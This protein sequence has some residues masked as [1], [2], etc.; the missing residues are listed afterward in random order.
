MQHYNCC[1]I[2]I[3]LCL[4]IAGVC[5]QGSFRKRL[6]AEVAEFKQDARSF[7]IEWD[8]HGPMIA[9]LDPVEAEHR[10][11]K[12]QPV[13]EVSAHFQSGSVGRADDVLLTF[14]SLP[15]CYH[16]VEYHNSEDSLLLYVMHAYTGMRAPASAAEEEEM[17]RSQKR[18]RAL[19]SMR[20]SLS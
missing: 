14:K 13:F 8:A 18:R 3:A 4:F 11:R 2:N 19:W 12:L 10:L 6:L 16:N 15:S 1:S 20:D 9:G 7:R 5:K 17:G